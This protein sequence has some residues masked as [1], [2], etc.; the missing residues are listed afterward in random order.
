MVAPM[1]PSG[2]QGS[3]V[4]SLLLCC[5]AWGWET[6]QK[7][8][9]VPSTQIHGSNLKCLQYRASD[10]KV[11]SWAGRGYGKLL[12]NTHRPQSKGKSLWVT[13][14]FNLKKKWPLLTRAS[15]CIALSSRHHAL[16][17]TWLQMTCSLRVLCKGILWGVS[18]P[19]PS[20]QFS[21]MTI[22]LHLLSPG[23]QSPNT[24]FDTVKFNCW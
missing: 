6:F 4:G 21:S 11:S 15:I 5:Q 16:T 18:A 12:T 23:T 19:S 9:H 22:F 14:A 24:T 3:G 2:L 20:Q 10:I 13:S 17:W 8:T 7:A 1:A